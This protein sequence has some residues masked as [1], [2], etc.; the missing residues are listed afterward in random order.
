VARGDSED[1][2][3]T[4]FASEN[5]LGNVISGAYVVDGVEWK[6]DGADIRGDGNRRTDEEWLSVKMTASCRISGQRFAVTATGRIYSAGE[7]CER[8]EA[9]R[10]CLTVGREEAAYWAFAGYSGDG[11]TIGARQ[12]DGDDPRLV[13]MAASGITAIAAARIAQWAKDDRK[14]AADTAKSSAKRA[15]QE[16]EKQ[17][18]ISAALD[19]I[20]K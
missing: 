15:Q 8:T 18:R 14:A 17:A 9:D 10:V 12:D 20:R 5:I 11:R 19:R 3:Q 16:A 13:E 7:W 6:V 1:D 2:M 4:I